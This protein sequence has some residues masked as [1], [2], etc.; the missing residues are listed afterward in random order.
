MIQ[1]S[2]LARVIPDGV[3]EGD[4]NSVTTTAAPCAK[5]KCQ[6]NRMMDVVIRMCGR[7]LIFLVCCTKRSEH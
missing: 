7:G 6:T 3:G 4:Y 5:Y 1:S 2:A